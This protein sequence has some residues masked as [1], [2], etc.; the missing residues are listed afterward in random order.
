MDRRVKAER[1]RERAVELQNEFSGVECYAEA[2]GESRNVNI[3]EYSQGVVG[4]M[5]IVLEGVRAEFSRCQEASNEL[6]RLMDLVNSA[7]T[8]ARTD[9]AIAQVEKFL[10]EHPEE[11]CEMDLGD[12]TT[13]TIRVEVLANR[14]LRTLES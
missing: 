6:G 1:A 3:D 12:G 14:I 9:S 10:D 4:L 13:I 2:N 8:Q 5:D 7:N 11:T